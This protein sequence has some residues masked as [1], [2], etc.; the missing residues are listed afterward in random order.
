MLL[1][2]WENQGKDTAPYSRT[3]EEPELGSSEDGGTQI[4]RAGAYI[5]EKK[6]GPGKI[7]C[8]FSCIGYPGY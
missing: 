3:G 7:P 8:I 4:R 2:D 6:V 1:P 5:G